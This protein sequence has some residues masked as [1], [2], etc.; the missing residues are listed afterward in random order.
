MWISVS[1]DGASQWK[2]RLVE[3]PWGAHW[4]L[5]AGEEGIGRR[6]YTIPLVSKDFPPDQ[7]PEPDPPNHLKEF[8]SGWVVTR[9]SG[10]S[11]Y[12]ALIRLQQCPGFRGGATWIPIL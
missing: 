7:E 3:T 12:R 11:I 6:L 8:G 9:S 5:E 1:I 4:Q 2:P 10:R